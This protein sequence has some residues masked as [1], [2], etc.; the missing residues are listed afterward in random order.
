MLD[1]ATP[2]GSVERLSSAKVLI[3]GHRQQKRCALQGWE[4]LR[5]RL[6]IGQ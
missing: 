3:V 4:D 5:Y 6:G 1:D 2:A